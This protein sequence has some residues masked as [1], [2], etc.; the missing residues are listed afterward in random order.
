MCCTCATVPEFLTVFGYF[1]VAVSEFF[2]VSGHVTGNFT[3]TV[4]EFLTVFGH[5][6]VTVF[7]FHIVSGRFAVTVDFI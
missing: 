7:E 4:S 2:I 3:V 1:T 5:V 6:T